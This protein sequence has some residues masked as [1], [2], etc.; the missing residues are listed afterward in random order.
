MAEYAAD[1]GFHI[2]IHQDITKAHIDYFIA[3]VEKFL[4]RKA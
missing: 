4:A 2:G 1:N 3:L